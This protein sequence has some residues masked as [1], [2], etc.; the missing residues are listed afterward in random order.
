MAIDPIS[1]LLIAYRDSIRTYLGLSGVA[2]ERTVAITDDG[3]PHPSSGQ[4]FYG[5]VPGPMSNNTTQGYIDSYLSF[6][7]VITLRAPIVPTDKAGDELIVKSGSE[8]VANSGGLNSRSWLL[9]EYLRTNRYS[10]MATANTL[11]G[12]NSSSRGF[13]EP[14]V[15]QGITFLGVKGA[16]W[17]WAEDPD[18]AP[19]GFAVRIDWN[20][21]RFVCE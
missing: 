6:G 13:V 20:L 16:D 5:L 10:I 8:G 21:C 9:S 17:F 4:Q 7:C 18:E 1:A 14:A 11:V 12:G 2:A 15:L 3:R 19:S